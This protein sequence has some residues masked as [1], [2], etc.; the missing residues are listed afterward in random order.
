MET[1]KASIVEKIMAVFLIITTILSCLYLSN[2]HGNKD[3]PITPASI[4]QI[5][6]TIVKDSIREKERQQRQHGKEANIIH[7]SIVV[8]VHHYHTLYDTLYKEADSICKI[9]LFKLNKASV[10]NDSLYNAELAKRALELKDAEFI[11]SSLID[12]ISI[13]SL[14][15]LFDQQQLKEAN[16]KAKKN[17][18]KGQLHGFLEGAAA[19][20]T[21]N[22][23]NQLKK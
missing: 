20:E 18:W 10:Y 5:R 3:Q 14:T 17:Y 2:C 8:H 11:K 7:D 12:V 16:K 4:L 15:H 22:V 19:V 9:A 1:N 23:I 21:G 13:D 6:K